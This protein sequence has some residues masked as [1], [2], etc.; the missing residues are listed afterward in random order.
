MA[1]G[2]FIDQH[3][4]I[5]DPVQRIDAVD[6]LLERAARDDPREHGVGVEE[7]HGLAR[8]PSRA[9]ATARRATSVPTS[10]SYGRTTPA[11][12]RS[13]RARHNSSVCHP[14]RALRMATCIRGFYRSGGSKTLVSISARLVRR[15]DRGAVGAMKKI[16]SKDGTPIAVERTGRGPALVFVDGAMCYRASGPSQPMAAAL[17]EHFTVFTYD[18]RGRGD[19]S[20]TGP[21]D[22]QR[23][24]DDL[25][26]VI[27]R[28]RR[29]GV[30]LRRVVGRGPRARGRQPR[31]A[32]D[33]ARPLRSAV[34]RG[35]QPSSAARRLRAAAE[36]G[37]RR[38]AAEATR[39]RCS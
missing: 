32:D 15:V 31:R 25:D 2:E 3:T 16:L 18:R 9:V 30:R 10:F 1:R 34:H 6:D 27:Q 21:Y 37:A 5:L 20:D 17:A 12:P 13:A 39:S 28:G 38:R 23:E 36:R 19:S 14:V 24:V 8:Q 35:Q 4:A 26:A 22:V 7:R 11:C 29:S 33:Q